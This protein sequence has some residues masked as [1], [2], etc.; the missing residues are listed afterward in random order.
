M[1]PWFGEEGEAEKENVFA[2][3]AVFCACLHMWAHASPG[4]YAYTHVHTF[5]QIHPCV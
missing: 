2:Q 4:T 5:M 1:E 3:S